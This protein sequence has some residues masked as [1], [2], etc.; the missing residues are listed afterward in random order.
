MAKW[1]YNL[2]GAPY[3][4]NPVFATRDKAISVAKAAL[5]GMDVPLVV[6][7]VQDGDPSFIVNVDLIL[8]DI[9]EIFTNRFGEVAN[10]YLADVKEVEKNYLQ[11]RLTKQVATWMQRE[12]YT[13]KFYTV[14]D[15][16]DIG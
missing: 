8:Q 15:I 1:T 11:E 3:W 14:Y 5:G 4:R 9:Q 7:K 12:N 13:P 2:K 6:A 16:E 10:D